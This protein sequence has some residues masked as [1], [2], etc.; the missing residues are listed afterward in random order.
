MKL[1]QTELKALKISIKH[2]N[3]L[4]KEYILHPDS[5]HKIYSVYKNCSRKSLLEAEKV[6]DN[7]YLKIIRILFLIFRKH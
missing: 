3:K 1:S 5:V 7:I 4:Y 6:Y 2:E